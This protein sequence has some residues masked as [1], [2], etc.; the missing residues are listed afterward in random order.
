[1]GIFR[2]IAQILQAELAFRSQGQRS[3]SFE[4][5]E[6]E[7]LR[8]I[9]EELRAE[10]RRAARQTPPP[11]TTGPVEW[12]YQTLGVAPTASNEQIKA[13][14]RRAIAQVHPDRFAHAPQ[15]QQR[16]AAERALEINRAYAI[17]KAVRNF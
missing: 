14:Y 16:A 1:M 3:G 12:A 10:P 17:L 5:S 4:S 11:R 13:A 8:N 15:Q 9:I 7:E 6:D 2:R